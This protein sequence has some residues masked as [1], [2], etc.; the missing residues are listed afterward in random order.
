MKLKIE[1]IRKVLS[2]N[3]IFFEV[4]VAT[5]LSFMAIKVSIEANRI[6]DNQTKIMYE[7]NLPQLEIRMTQEYNTQLKIYDNDVWLFFNRGGKLSDFD[8]KE[9]SFYRFTYRPDYDTLNIPLDSYLNMRGII[10]GESEGLVYQIDNNHHGAKEIV[11]RDSLS[12]FGY[13]DIDTYVAIYYKDI[14]DE[15]HEE[16]FQISPGINKINKQTWD[17]IE[18]SYKGDKNRYS[19]PNLSAKNVVD[20]TRNNSR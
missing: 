20:M 8:T 14:F 10:T 15:K 2:D 17:R 19:F 18:A 6:A 5:L 1:K 11:L 12:K 7:E 9:Y 13:Y 3:K 4:I 16:F